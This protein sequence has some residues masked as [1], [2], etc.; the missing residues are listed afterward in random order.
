MS[1]WFCIA[2]TSKFGLGGESIIVDVFKRLSTL[3]QANKI[4]MTLC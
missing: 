2:K 3:L 1:S 4:R